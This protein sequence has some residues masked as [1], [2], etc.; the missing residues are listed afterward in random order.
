MSPSGSE[1]QTFS[2]ATWI[3][4][5]PV[6]RPSVL[7]ASGQMLAACG[8]H[9]WRAS[10]LRFGVEPCA[11]LQRCPTGSRQ[12]VIRA[13]TGQ[14][15]PAQQRQMGFVGPQASLS[16]VLRGCG[17]PGAVRRVPKFKLNCLRADTA[18]R[19]PAKGR[20]G[21]LQH[22]AYC[23]ESFAPLRRLAQRQSIA[24]RVSIES[25]ADPT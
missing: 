11:L 3:T 13:G 5:G 2:D 16:G 6:A 8:I 24:T 19:K 1:C 4:R 20:W 12:H 7:H 21:N 22:P 10:S 18:R 17:S 14:R 25:A 15:L 9:S 23:T